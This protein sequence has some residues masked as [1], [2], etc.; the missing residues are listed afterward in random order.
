MSLMPPS[1]QRDL[2]LE[3]FGYKV[4]PQGHGYLPLPDGSILQSGDEAQGP[5]VDRAVLQARRRPV[6]EVRG[7]DRPDR[8]H[9]GPAADG[10]AA[11]RRVEEARRHQG[12]RA[13]RLA[14]P[15]GDRPADGRRHHAAVHDERD[16][17]APALVRERGVHRAAVRERHHR[18]VGRPGRARHRV[19]DDAPL[20]RR[21]RRRR[22]R[23]LGLPRGR[24]GRGRRRVCRRGA[25]LRRR[26]PHERA[27][28]ACARCATAARPA[29]R[30]TGGEELSAPLVVTA[31]HP[32]IT[33][34]EQ[35]ER[36]RAAR[37]RSSRTSRTGG[38][39]P[40]R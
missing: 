7:V 38:R 3:R 25:V 28:R 5:R 26:D 20:G 33:F 27:R 22:D 35:I 12:R 2:E 30:S 24:H 14:A 40:A 10:D 19:R 16:R 34:L 11:A 17:P 6:A 13:A 37:R 29:S 15:Q 39:A 21:H 4:F 23:E 1:I 32:K 8:E 36:S 31:I 9:H 18:H